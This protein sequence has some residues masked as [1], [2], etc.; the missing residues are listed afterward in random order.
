MTEVNTEIPSAVSLCECTVV[1]DISQGLAG[2][3]GYSKSDY[4]FLRFDRARI[5]T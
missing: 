2:R 1:E 4:F 3:K 5:I